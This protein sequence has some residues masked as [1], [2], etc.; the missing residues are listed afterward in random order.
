MLKKSLFTIS[1]LSLSLLTSCASTLSLEKYQ[2]YTDAKPKA[3]GVC[4]PFGGVEK[5]NNKATH[6]QNGA[7]IPLE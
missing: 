3:D 7:Y 4:A 5:F 6:C 1:V 2:E